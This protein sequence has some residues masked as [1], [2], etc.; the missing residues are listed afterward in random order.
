MHFKAYQVC[1]IR[2]KVWY[3]Y[4]DLTM[5]SVNTRRQFWINELVNTPEIDSTNLLGTFSKER[6]SV[7]ISCHSIKLN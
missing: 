1:N 2:F 7:T 3:V 6:S 4:N 5:I